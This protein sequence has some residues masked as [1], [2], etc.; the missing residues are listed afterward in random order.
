VTTNET[1]GEP[2]VSQGTPRQLNR[3][4]TGA[5]ES[6]PDRGGSV[7][8]SP[9]PLLGSGLRQE[10]A[11]AASRAPEEAAPHG[12]CQVCRSP[13]PEPVRRADG[14]YKG[15][16]R[17]L[18]YPPPKDCKERAQA[19]RDARVAE[20]LSDPLRLVAAVAEEAVPAMTETQAV[21]A[22]AIEGFAAITGVTTAQVA[23]ANAE[24]EAARQETEAARHRAD[25]AEE[26][27]AQAQ[28]R[29]DLDRAA[30]A[31]AEQAAA[32]ARTE[33]VQTKQ[34]AAETIAA[35]RQA[36]VNAERA[37]A[38]AR[39]AEQSLA[40]RL[41]AAT[42]DL[43]EER[44][45]REQLTTRLAQCHAELTAAQTATQAAQNDTR[46]A[47]Q[48]AETAERQAA[49]AQQKAAVTAALAD[50]AERDGQALTLQVEKLRREGERARAE[51]HRLAAES[52]ALRDD[53]DAA[54]AGAAA[55]RERAAQAELRARVA[56]EELAARDRLIV[57]G[58]TSSAE[59]PKPAEPGSPSAGTRV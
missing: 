51:V 5:A 41:E 25:Q 31:D 11:D 14:R 17:R 49:D 44:Q 55:Q 15:G 1:S 13:L 36:A 48:R 28:A 19:M 45:A 9:T 18:Y 54:R 35:H 12:R 30:R 57:D 53:R 23:E 27:A 29:S 3:E 56:R 50:R 38:L 6:T 37:A 59:E 26:R 42:D 2:Q 22:K 10:D 58:G 33:A 7:G 39:Q 34:Q 21:L 4:A 32:Q 24:V 43:E 40:V 47:R 16:R 8:S 52:Q 20:A 46:A